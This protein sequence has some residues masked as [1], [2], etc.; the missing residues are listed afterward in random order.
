MQQLVEVLRA[1]QTQQAQ[2]EDASFCKEQSGST[3]VDRLP[4]QCTH[5]EWQECGH[6]K[7][8]VLLTPSRTTRRDGTF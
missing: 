7:E 6:S 5:V 4:K 1:K 2:T 8:A 3:K